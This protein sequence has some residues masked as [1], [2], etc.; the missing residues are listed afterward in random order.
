MLGKP[1]AAGISVAGAWM[2]IKLAD[3]LV[4]FGW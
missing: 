3:L 1:S 2:L 4:K